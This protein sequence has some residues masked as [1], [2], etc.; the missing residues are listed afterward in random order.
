MLRYCSL[1]CFIIFGFHEGSKGNVFV[2]CGGIL[3]H[4]IKNIISKQV[5]INIIFISILYLPAI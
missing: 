3:K 1:R 2:I 4:D 5:N